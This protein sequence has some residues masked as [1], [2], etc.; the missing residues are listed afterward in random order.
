MTLFQSEFDAILNDAS[1]MVEGNI[2]WQEES[3][4]FKF[5]ADIQTQSGNYPLSIRGTCNPTILALS[6]AMIYPPYGRIYGLDLGKEHRNPNGEQVGENHKHRWSE[7][8]RDKEAYVPQDIT[9]SGDDPITVWQQFCHE[10]SIRHDGEMM[11][12][13]EQQLDLFL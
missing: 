11:P 3:L 12:I 2:T 10:A 5:K 1:K 4:W 7:T 8:Y 9:A 13:P 6:Y